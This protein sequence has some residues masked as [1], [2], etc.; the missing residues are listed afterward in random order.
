MRS[1]PTVSVSPSRTSTPPAIVAPATA[2]AAIR[3]RPRIHRVHRPVGED[4][5]PVTI[6]HVTPAA[7]IE[8]RIGRLRE[9]LARGRP[10]RRRDR[11]ARRPGLLLGH[12]PAGAP[13]RAGR[14]RAAAAR[15]ARARAG[16]ARVAARA[17]RAAALALGA[18]RRAR[19]TRASG[20]GARVGFE[21]DV[22]PAPRLPRLRAAACRGSSSATART[23]CARCARVKSAW[24][25][26]QMRGRL[27]AGAPRRRGGAGADRRRGERGS[28]F[29][30]RSSG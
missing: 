23:S 26:E 1:C 22:L 16:A 2:S 15:A 20:P 5:A 3:G 28:T 4:H 17:D 21:L 6:G 13:G 10:R 25:L 7:E 18:A 24:D 12:E 30:S 14:R 9:G 29:S 27:R 11:A 19:R 8:R